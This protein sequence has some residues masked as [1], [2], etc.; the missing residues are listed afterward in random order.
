[1]G[2]FPGGAV[3]KTLHF[4]CKGAGL[5]PGGGAKIPHAAW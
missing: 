1:M 2:D 5:I 4:Q 3:V